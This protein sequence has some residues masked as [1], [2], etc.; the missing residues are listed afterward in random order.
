M[1]IQCI[2]IINPGTCKLLLALAQPCFEINV[3]QYESKKVFWYEKIKKKI[4]MITLE[5][6]F[7]KQYYNA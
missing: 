1:M 6:M 5:D 2:L 3:H 4:K 7:L